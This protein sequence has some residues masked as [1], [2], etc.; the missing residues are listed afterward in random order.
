MFRRVTNEERKSA[1][2]AKRQFQ[3]SQ[4][5]FVTLYK[6]YQAWM[7]VRRNGKP[8]N[9]NNSSAWAQGPPS[10]SE[11]DAENSYM[12]LDS[13]SSCQTDISSSSSSSSD[14]DEDGEENEGTDLEE[15]EQVWILGLLE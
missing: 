4:G 1:D 13:E 6:V 7:S 10:D 5:D 11:S 9:L 8:N 15:E 14:S 2:E 12:S 3:S